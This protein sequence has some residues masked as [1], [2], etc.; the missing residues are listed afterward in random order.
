MMSEFLQGFLAGLDIEITREDID[1][2]TCEVV[3]ELATKWKTMS[4]RQQKTLLT[5]L[6]DNC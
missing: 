4:D 1:V 2:D 6:V 5:L 3:D